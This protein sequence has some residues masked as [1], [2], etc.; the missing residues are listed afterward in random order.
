MDNGICFPL[1]VS[2]DFYFE[3]CSLVGIIITSAEGPKSLARAG[4]KISAF[5]CGKE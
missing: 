3:C 4:A 5:W 1:L 2:R